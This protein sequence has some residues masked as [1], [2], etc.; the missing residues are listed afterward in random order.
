VT[1]IRIPYFDN[2][3][4]SRFDDEVAPGDT[5]AAEAVLASFL[6]LTPTDRIADSRHVFAYYR[7]YHE[8]VGGKDWL[9]AEMGVPQTAADIWHSVTPGPVTVGK[10]DGH[11]YVAMEAECRWE[12]EHGL[13]MVWRDGMTLSKV[14]GYDGH[15]TNGAAYANDSLKDVVYAA[16][17]EKY[18]TRLTDP[19]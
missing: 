19:S 10:H 11:W 14:G 9:D 15:M 4:V 5:A 3:E 6:A 18:T 17:K 2:A 8:A 12:P 1:S 7:D 13:M 16:S